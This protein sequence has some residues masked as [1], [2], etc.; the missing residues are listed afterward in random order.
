MMYTAPTSKVDR[1]HKGAARKARVALATALVATGLVI[2]P[3]AAGLVAPPAHAATTTNPPIVVTF[4]GDQG[5][6]D[7]ND[8]VCD[9]SSASSQDCTLRA[10]IQVANARPGHDEIDFAV[11]EGFVDPV[12][13]V[14]TIKPGSKLPAITDTVTIDGYTQPGAEK[15]TLAKGTNAFGHK[16]YWAASPGFFQQ[17]DPGPRDQ[18]LRHRYRTRRRHGRKSH[19]GQLHWHRPD[20]HPGPG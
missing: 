6:L 8:G 19:R 13:G 1:L 15:N 7:P 20:R 16:Q 14:A 4:N 17:R 5:D 3:L 12:T 10:A 9:I 11:P 18:P 2:P